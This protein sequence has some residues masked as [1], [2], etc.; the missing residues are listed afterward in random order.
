M[1]DMTQKIISLD[2]ESALAL[3]KALAASM[4]EKKEADLRVE[5]LWEEAESDFKKHKNHETEILEKSMIQNR[6]DMINAVHRKME[7]FDKN[8]NIDVM[9]EDLLLVAR[10]RICH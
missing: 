8:V 4:E 5:K 3:N 9:V 6:D 2:L 1:T 10:D 7:M